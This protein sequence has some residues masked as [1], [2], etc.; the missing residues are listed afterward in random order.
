MLVSNIFAESSLTTILEVCVC[1]C[2]L[3]NVYVVNSGLGQRG[4]GQKVSPRGGVTWEPLR[5]WN[6]LYNH[7]L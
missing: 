7:L 6:H 3:L 4:L 1:V 5:Y 2:V